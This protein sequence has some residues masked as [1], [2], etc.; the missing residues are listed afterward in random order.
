MLSGEE[1]NLIGHEKGLGSEDLLALGA[2]LVMGVAIE[3]DANKIA[4]ILQIL[5]AG[6]SVYDIDTTYAAPLI[7]KYSQGEESTC[8]RVL[9]CLI[10]NYCSNWLTKCSFLDLSVDTR[11][12]D[13]TCALWKL[14][15]LMNMSICPS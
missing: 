7:R 5:V 10:I 13:M 11:W 4:Q 3:L 12:V 1:I 15:T 9:C 8:G 14:W 6:Y 2:N